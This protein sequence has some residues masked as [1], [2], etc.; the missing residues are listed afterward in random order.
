MTILVS[1]REKKNLKLDLLPLEM[2][3]INTNANSDSFELAQKN[4]L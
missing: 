4:L 1:T 2:W 3:A